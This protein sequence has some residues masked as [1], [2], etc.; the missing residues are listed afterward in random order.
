MQGKEWGAAKKGGVMKFKI[1]SFVFLFLFMC[2]SFALAKERSEEYLRYEEL[3]K[4]IRLGNVKTIN[5]GNYSTISGAYLSDGEEKLFLSR[6]ETDAANDPLLMD[7]LLDNN[8]KVNLGKES[9]KRS[10]AGIGLAYGLFIYGLVLC[11]FF[12][13]SDC[14]SHQP[15]KNQ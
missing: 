2:A 11:I 15:C 8:V 13:R 1:P 7:L 6:H 10:P 3:I 4:Q 14:Y 12:W 5:V 9:N